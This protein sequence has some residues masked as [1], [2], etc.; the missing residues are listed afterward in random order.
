MSRIRTAYRL[1][2]ETAGEVADDDVPAMAASIAYFALLSLPPL[3]AL[4][5]GLIGIFYGDDEARQ[6]L[7]DQAS[8]V[9]GADGGQQLGTMI[10][11]AQDIAGGSL[12]GQ[13]VGIGAI[14]FG[15][16]G[17][18][19]WLQRSL[20]KAWNVEPDP[21]GSG[22]KQFIFK[23]FL[24][25][26]MILTIGFL[27]A[28][29]LVLSAILRI[30]GQ[31]LSDLIG[32]AGWVLV[33]VGDIVLPLLIFTLL[34][35][36]IFK[37]LPDAR[38]RWK[39]VWIG[40]FATTVLF[41]IGRYL[42]GIYIGQ[43]DPGEAFGAAGTLVVILI[44]IYFTAFL[45]LVGAEFTQVWARHVGQKIIADDGAV[46]VI[47]ERR[48][49]RPDGTVFTLDDEESDEQKDRHS[50][51]SEREPRERSGTTPD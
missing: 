32:G 13:I 36:A 10:Q 27:L 17:A 8:E 11:Q 24:S 40:A 5:V 51:A 9:L 39:D 16:T 50:W 2:K 19:M 25:F 7:V 31:E 15:A 21:E 22:I 3:L 1:I 12:I 37:F 33:Q 29:S 35:A 34:F 48:Y 30:I 14:I 43:A 6:E 18:F 20:N 28:I 45:L 41:I 4:V 38:I 23:R 46:R 42:I 44:W 47:D 49:E 26:G